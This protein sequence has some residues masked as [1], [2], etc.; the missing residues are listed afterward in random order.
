M[1]IYTLITSMCSTNTYVLISDGQAIA[2]DPGDGA[3]EICEFIKS[4]NAIL[5]YILITHAHFDHIGAV[6]ELQKTGASVYI[7]Q[8]D[9]EHVYVNE[10][11]GDFAHVQP[12]EAD[13]FIKEG[14]KFE[15][16]GHKFEVIE[17]P[18]H[19]AGG[20]CYIMDDST[21]FSGDTLFRS[22]V[23]RTDLPFGDYAAIIKSI[24]KLFALPHD[25]EVLP[26]HSQ[27]TTLDFERRN[28]PYVR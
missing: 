10:Q 2:V 27:R 11:F 4:K 3:T 14:D 20:V 26:G 16:C 21:I 6:S 28:N 7:S 17:T 23:G 15:L 8:T 18:G 13:V 9:Y 22:S 12:F 1:E 5:K 25:Y 19:T 24:K